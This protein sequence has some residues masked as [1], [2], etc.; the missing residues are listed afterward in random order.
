M[1]S[2]GCPSFRYR[3]SGR[4]DLLAVR[5]R[6]TSRD[7]IR[8]KCQDRPVL[9]GPRLPAGAVSASCAQQ[10]LRLG[11]GARAGERPCN[12]MT[13]RA[14][15]CKYFPIRSGAGAVAGNCDRRVHGSGHHALQIL[16]NREKRSLTFARRAPSGKASIRT[17]QAADP[18]ISFEG[19]SYGFTGPAG[20]FFVSS[21]PNPNGDVGP[22][23]SV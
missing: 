21:S 8:S 22:N 4:D 3:R 16:R 23:S 5:A 10:G 19:L 12:A 13:T 18:L 2:C 15:M 20:T 14:T 7:L 11:A 6:G 9:R 17:L 1:H